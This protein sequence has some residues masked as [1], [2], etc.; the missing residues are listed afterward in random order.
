MIYGDMTRE[1]T[2]CSG[3]CVGGCRDVRVDRFVPGDNRDTVSLPFARNGL[4]G[5]RLLSRHEN[6]TLTRALADS[7]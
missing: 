1:C 5:M 6:S 4:L 7:H 2:G 3:F